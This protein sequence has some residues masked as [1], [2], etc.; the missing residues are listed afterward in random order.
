[1]QRI[2]IRIVALLALTVNGIAVGFVSSAPLASPTFQPTVS[3]WQFLSSST[4]H[5]TAAQCASVGRRCSVPVAMAHSYNYAGLL[6]GGNQGQ[7]ITI[8]RGDSFGTE[9]IRRALHG[10]AQ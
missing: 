5:P 3:D 7:G 4:T 10:S 8:A 1:M 2:L 6:A 9:T